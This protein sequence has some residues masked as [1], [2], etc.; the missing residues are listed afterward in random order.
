MSAPNSITTQASPSGRRSISAFARLR[1]CRPP[2]NGAV[3]ALDRD[4]REFLV[5]GHRVGRDI[6]VGKT[7]HEDDTLRRALDQTHL[8][9]QR[10]RAGAFG[11]DQGPCDVEAV[12]GQQL[13]EI[14]ARDAPLNIRK[15][16]ADQLGVAV[17]QHAQ[18]A[19]DLSLATTR[20]DDRFEFIIAG[21]ADPEAFAV[22]GQHFERFDVLQGL[23][24]H[25]GVRT[26]GV[27]GDHA[28]QTAA[29]VRGRVGREGQAVLLGGV[30]EAVADHA[31]LDQG[32]P[33][34]GIQL[35]DAIAESRRVEH[36][37]DVD[38]LPAH[39]CAAAT[40][41]HRRL[42]AA[43]DGHGCREVLQRSGDDNANR[44]LAVVGRVRRVGGPMAIVETH[45]LAERAR[46][47][48]GQRRP[49]SGFVFMALA[50]IG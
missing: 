7:K 32:G 33:P 16:G 29:T 13:I 34:D 5:F 24:G 10:Q 17:P 31:R 44:H 38:R 30:A 41:Q 1:A 42:V 19:V 15:P 48:T 43:A 2:N 27:V 3:Q 4:G 6:D 12:F 18:P 23:A 40:H 50:L 8:G 45:G 36:Y 22:V 26:A 11:A 28:A 47:L 35:Q 39:R 21:R 9:A 46:Q 25:D 37:G 49:L 14:V 20:G